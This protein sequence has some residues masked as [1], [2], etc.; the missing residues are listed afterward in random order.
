[1]ENP[2]LL[3][4]NLRG[5]GRFYLRQGR[6]KEGRA[7][8]EESLGVRLPKEYDAFNRIPCDTYRMW[9]REEIEAGNYEEARKLAEK[10]REEVKKIEHAQFRRTQKAYIDLLFTRLDSEAA[11]QVETRNAV[12]DLRASSRE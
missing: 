6:F 4:M 7:R 10:A 12:G 9:A 3:A 11:G 1:V 5:L 2:V 8:Y